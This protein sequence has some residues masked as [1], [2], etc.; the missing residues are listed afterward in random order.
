MALAALN[1]LLIRINGG[2]LVRTMG[3]HTLHVSE[4]HHHEEEI[5][6]V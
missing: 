2:I 4:Q 6:P 1:G 3:V 5:S